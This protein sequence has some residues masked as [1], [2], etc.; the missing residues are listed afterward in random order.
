MTEMGS[1][2]YYLITILITIVGAVWTL[3]WWLSSKFSEVR[4]LVF[5]QSDELRQL[6]T[7]K[8]DYHE[9]HDDQRFQAINNDLWAIRLRN[10][11]RDGLLPNVNQEHKDLA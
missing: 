4:N 6:F 7:S 2:T 10:A 9:R 8:L 5:S 11:S 3:A 1:E